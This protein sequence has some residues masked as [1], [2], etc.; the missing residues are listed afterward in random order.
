MTQTVIFNFPKVLLF[1][2]ESLR[3]NQSIHMHWVES[4][5]IR[6]FH[7][8][9]YMC[10]TKLALYSFGEHVVRHKLFGRFSKFNWV[11]PEE[12]FENSFV[13]TLSRSVTARCKSHT[14]F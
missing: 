12:S 6:N 1:G 8:T 9:V 13:F 11:V 4:A 10:T 5:I 2:L 3:N 7:L 14:K